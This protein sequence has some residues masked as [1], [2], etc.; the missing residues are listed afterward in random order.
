M[1]KIT[2]L[3]QNVLCVTASMAR[4]RARS[5]S[6]TIALGVGKFVALP[7][8]WSFGRY[9][10]LNAGQKPLDCA[11]LNSFRKPSTRTWSGIAKPK[12][13]TFVVVLTWSGGGLA[14]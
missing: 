6:A 14:A 4:P 7:A 9:R 12:P 8:V 13:D 10:M 3:L 1:T 5:L 11:A 2:V